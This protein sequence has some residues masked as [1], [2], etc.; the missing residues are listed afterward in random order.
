MAIFGWVRLEHI[1]PP[2]EICVWGGLGGP[3]GPRGAP[4]GRLFAHFSSFFL[5]KTLNRFM[6][7]VEIEYSVLEDS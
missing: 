2:T 1:P 5:Q 3:G 7:E 4:G 6:K